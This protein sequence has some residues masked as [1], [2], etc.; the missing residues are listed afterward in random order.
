MSQKTSHPVIMKRIEPY[1]A[2]TIEIWK[3]SDRGIELRVNGNSMY[4][5]IKAGSHIFI[6]LS[7]PDEIRS[8]DIIAF[9]KNQNVVVHRL[10]KKRNENGHM[11]LCEKGDNC[12]GWTWINEKDVLGK[13][14]LVYN[15]NSA[16]NMLHWPWT[17]INPALGLLMSA[18]VSLYEK[19][20]AMKRIICGD[21]SVPIFLK[22][23]VYNIVSRIFVVIKVMIGM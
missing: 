15:S 13:I 6:R 22:R 11:G 12:T 5:L 19:T 4:P 23:G 14:E 3:E 7:G 10:I 1:I 9:W 20:R 18:W 21:R 16:M 8:G 2:S 17:L